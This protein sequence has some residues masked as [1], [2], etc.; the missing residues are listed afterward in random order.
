MLTH[1]SLKS[2]FTHLQTYR[3]ALRA[4]QL[5]LNV[6]IVVTVMIYVLQGFEGKQMNA[7]R[8]RRRSKAK[9]HS[10][11]KCHYDHLCQG[12]DHNMLDQSLRSTR[13]FADRIEERP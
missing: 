3:P 7:V 10:Q 1:F 4:T 13:P 9:S 5:P 6:H 11:W 12:H 2:T 8:T